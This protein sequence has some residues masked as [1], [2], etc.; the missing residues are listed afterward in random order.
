MDVL[1]R[2]RELAATLPPARQ[3]QALDFVEFLAARAQATTDRAG[4]WCDG[5]VRDVADAAL[6]DEHDPVTYARSDGR[7]TR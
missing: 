2:I 4:E 6:V 7:T 1:E 5:G 3:A